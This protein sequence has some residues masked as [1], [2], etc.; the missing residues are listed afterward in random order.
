MTCRARAMFNVFASV[1]SWPHNL[2]CH[3]FSFTRRFVLRNFDDLLYYMCRKLYGSFG[4]QVYRFSP[5]TVVKT[6]NLPDEL[7]VA[8]LGH[9][10]RRVGSPK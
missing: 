4:P 2:W 9:L 6:S 10:P 5:W 3:L 8:V 7:E 1:C